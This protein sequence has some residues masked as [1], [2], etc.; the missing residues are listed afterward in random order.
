[1][2]QIELLAP[3]RDLETG[4]AAINCGA[5]AIYIGA[6]NFGAREAASNNLASIEQ[7]VQY[8]HKYWAKVYVTL[9]TLLTD[10]EIPVAVSL[11]KNL[12]QVGIDALIIQ[13]TGLLE[14][15]LPP[16]PLFASTQMHNNSAERVRFLE[17]VGFQRAILARE[18]SIQ[19]I[20]EIHTKTNIELECF[21]HGA[22]CV[23]YSGQ[24]YMS[25]ALGGRSGNKGQCAQPCRRVYKLIDQSGN[26][27]QDNS[28][29][30]SLRDLNLSEYLQELIDA[31]VT[32]FKI[33]G[34]L[35]D[36]PY[37]MN[38]VSHYRQKLDA[39]LE[40]NSLTR[41]SSGQSYP[42]FSPNPLKTFN[43]GYT[44][45]FLHG[46]GSPLTSWDTPKSIGEPVGIITNIDRSSF[47]LDTTNPFRSGD[48]CCFFD[49]NHQL[50]GTLINE[51][52]NQ[53]IYPEKIEGMYIGAMIYRNHDHLF[54]SSLMKSRAE[55]K[56]SLQFQLEETNRG[57]ELSAIDED[58]NNAHFEMECKKIAAE[59][60]AQV[61][62]TIEKQLFKLGSTEFICKKLD[63]NP[64]DIGFIP[65]S[66]LNSLRR[67]VLE[68]LQAARGLNRP[69]LKSE[70]IPNNAPF[71][72]EEL[73]FSGN[74]LN[75]KA[76]AFYQRHG[77]LDIAPAAESGL[78]MQG[79]K[80]MTTKYCLKYQLGFC[81]KES[82]S[83][84]LDE[85]MALVD[86]QGNS[87]PLIFNCQ[88][89]E[90]EIYFERKR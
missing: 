79:K 36:K 89:C 56:I 15:D 39:I 20:K 46:R 44:S 33:E 62:A 55:R 73:S 75:K 68:N 4:L 59:K 13:D 9:N 8:A 58:G 86:E 47:T 30:L 74:V 27:L 7:L 76:R 88:H 26:I 57:Y 51:I 24:C 85:P 34:R 82:P 80:V 43:R 65:V 70:H 81:P 25:Y 6:T 14:C 87:Y 21:I 40:K 61:I 83:S 12:Y 50:C 19:Q 16:I 64:P 66:N 18:L 1:L 17:Q 72:G 69:R 60:P 3:A 42:D 22:L 2:K 67:G 11:V 31:G 63:I 54:L 49:K 38:T 48:G 52:N 78:D 90:M 5:D 53:W 28:H 71:P 37:V 41:D 35:K 29:L 10:S 45:Y 77:V 84:K 23:S 32:S